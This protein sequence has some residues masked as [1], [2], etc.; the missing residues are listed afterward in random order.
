MT[1]GTCTPELIDP[2]ATFITTRR[3]TTANEAIMIPTNGA[4]YNFTI[5]WGDGS[6]M[7]NYSGTAPNP[8]HTYAAA[9]DHKV[10]IFGSFPRFVMSNNATY[11]NKLISVDQWGAIQRTSMDNAFQ[12]CENLQILATDTPNLSNVTSMVSMFYGATN[13]TGN[14]SG[15]N[16]SNVTHMAQMFYGATNF[17]QPLNSWDVSKVTNMNYMFSNATK[18]NQDLSNWNTSKVTSMYYT[19]Y[20]ANSFNGD[21]STWDTSK[22]TTMFGMF[23][24]ASSFN[25]DLSNWDVGNV[26][27]M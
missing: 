19:F 11:R 27:D 4:G 2:T 25:G 5:D 26:T 6:A 21:I 22:V 8:I 10:T 23:Y 12:G 16:T 3:T 14:F 13:L 24:G 9:G 18:F 20:Y 7:E 1:S 17:N 15:W